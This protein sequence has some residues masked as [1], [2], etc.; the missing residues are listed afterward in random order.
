M[1]LPAAIKLP[2]KVRKP[3][4]TSATSAPVLNGEWH[5]RDGRS[6]P[7]IDTRR[8]HQA[9]G[10]AAEGVRE[11]GSLG[12]GR[13]RHHGQGHADNA[14]E[15]ESDG[16]PVVA[17]ISGQQQRTADCGHHG[18]HAGEYAPPG[19]AGVAHPH[20]RE[21]EQRRRNQ[22]NRLNN[23]VMLMTWQAPAS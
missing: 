21:D 7:Q 12:Y 19:R 2:V 17:L 11:R 23:S 3:R 6:H 14:A 22:I 1:S 5:G 20:Q 16:D 13:Q 9:G 8:R 15:H 4:I 10:Q 18:D